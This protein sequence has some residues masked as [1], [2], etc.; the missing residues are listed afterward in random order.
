M[1][2]IKRIYNWIRDS[3]NEGDVYHEFKLN[4]DIDSIVEVDLR[5]NCPPVYNQGKLGSCTANAIAGAYQFDE[6][7]ENEKDQIT[8]SRLFI[9][10]NERVIDGTVGQDS[11]AQIKTSVESITKYGTCSE[12]LWPYDISKF[13][14]KPPEECYTQAENHKCVSAKRVKQTLNDMKQC[15]I[16]GY[17]FVL[18]FIVYPNFE[19]WETALTGKVSMPNL[20]DTPLGGHAVMV[21]GFNDKDKVFIVRNSWGEEWGDNGYFYMPYDYFTNPDLAS[22]LWTVR[23][24]VDN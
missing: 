11:G 7:K 14:D 15:L 8:P 3:S 2:Q 23:S 20:D 12:Q 24:V 21:V 17:P 19:S 10:Y 13:A 22:D 16:D 1:S 4:S 9:Y 5:P 6:M 18:G